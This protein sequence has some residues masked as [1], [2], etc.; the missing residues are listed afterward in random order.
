MGR[1]YPVSKSSDYGSSAQR[2]YFK[3]V[4]RVGKQNIPHK[5]NKP[6]RKR[7]E[8]DGTG[9]ANWSGMI[10]YW[11]YYAW[12]VQFRRDDTRVEGFLTVDKLTYQK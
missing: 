1:T 5:K 7:I 10:K 8:F 3:D 12:G 2:A 11:R 6:Y 4:K 9:K